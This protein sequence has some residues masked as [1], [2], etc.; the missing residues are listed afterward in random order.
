[1]SYQE[2]ID[3]LINSST[4]ENNYLAMRLM[5]D[6]THLNFEKAFLK[7]I[8]SQKFRF[9]YMIEIADIRIS[10]ALQLSGLF[11]LNT[12]FT[13]IDCQIFFKKILVYDS[14]I[15]IDLDD[16]ELLQLALDNKITSFSEIRSD[17]VEIAPIVKNLFYKMD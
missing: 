8:L 4:K 2:K 11:G 7:L 10:Y 3:M 15:E 12:E 6:V 16:N 9:C 17:L 1:M 14:Q 13:E 5:V